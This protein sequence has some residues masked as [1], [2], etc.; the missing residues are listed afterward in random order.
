M[1]NFN[2]ACRIGIQACIEQLGQSFVSEHKNCATSAFGLQ[3]NSVFCYVGIY[4]EFDPEIKSEQLIL[5]SC[6]K[7][8]YYASC[9][10][11]MQSGNIEF[12]ECILPKQKEDC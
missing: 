2:E 12:I 5:D 4:S 1:L 3:N 8:T 7:F 6:S 11:S 10:V 9:F